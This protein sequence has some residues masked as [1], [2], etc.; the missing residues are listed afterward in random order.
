[1]KL[2]LQYLIY[3]DSKEAHKIPQTLLEKKL[4]FCVKKW[5]KEELRNNL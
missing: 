5:L 3:A 4:V 1:M 2:R